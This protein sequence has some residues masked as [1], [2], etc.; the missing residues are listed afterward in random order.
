MMLEV[1]DEVCDVESWFQGLSDH[2]ITLQAWSPR[3]D[4]SCQDKL[5]YIQ[6]WLSHKLQQ[7]KQ[8]IKKTK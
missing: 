1:C 2:L 6:Q 4:V 8:K 3:A 5:L 7:S